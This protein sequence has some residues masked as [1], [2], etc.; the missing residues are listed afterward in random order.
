M[1]KTIEELS[2]ALDQLNCGQTV[3][4]EDQEINDLLEVA[5]LLRNANLANVSIAPSVSSDSATVAALVAP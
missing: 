1:N 3:E 5:T 4:S 2:I